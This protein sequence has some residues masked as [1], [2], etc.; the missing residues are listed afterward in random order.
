MAHTHRREPEVLIRHASQ[1]ADQA[2][3]ALLDEY[4]VPALVEAFVRERCC[5]NVRAASTAQQDSIG[6]S[7]RILPIE[8]PEAYLYAAAKVGD[9]ITV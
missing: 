1:R 9:N 7:D 4:L 8:P 5:S 3:R 2:V 6:P